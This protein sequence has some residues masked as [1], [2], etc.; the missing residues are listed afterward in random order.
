M[1]TH[2]KNKVVDKSCFAKDK[3]LSHVGGDAL[4]PPTGP[5]WNRRWWCWG[6]FVL[7]S[8]ADRLPARSLSWSCKKTVERDFWKNAAVCLSSRFVYTRK[9]FGTF[10]VGRGRSR[11]GLQ[12]PGCTWET[13][14]GG[15]LRTTSLKEKRPKISTDAFMGSL[16][17]TGRRVPLGLEHLGLGI[18]TGRQNDRRW[19]LPWMR[20]KIWHM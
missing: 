4:A 12:T 17:T 18:A 5:C 15:C 10:S 19:E 9:L 20:Q 7:S 11:E 1:K 14:R 8:P 16:L 3:R 6:W 2:K 13:H